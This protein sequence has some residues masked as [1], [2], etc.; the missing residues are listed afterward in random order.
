[1][2][3]QA[4]LSE[5]G[6]SGQEYWS[7]L[8]STGCNTFL[9]HCISCYPSCQPP[10]STW[11]RQN[12]CN[13][14]SSTTSTPGPHSGKL[15]P[16]RAACGSSAPVRAEREGGAA[17]WLAG[18]LVASS[19][20]GHKLP[21]RQELW[22]YQSLFSG[23]LKLVIRRLLWL[24]FLRSSSRWTTSRATPV[25]APHVEVEIKSQLKHRGSVAKDEKPK[26]SHQLYKA[27]D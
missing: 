21:P 15:K 5:R 26:P 8:A 14:S 17:A 2:A 9:E 22:P 24:V 1:M 12:P 10:L 13:P 3:F 23:L 6:L 25:D 4:S 7:I 16:S 27:A 11:C 18:T 19:V 20:Q